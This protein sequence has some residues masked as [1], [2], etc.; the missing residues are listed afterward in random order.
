MKLQ[1]VP[2]SA[3]PGE[4]DV[5]GLPAGFA[6]SV[7]HAGHCWRVTLLSEGRHEDLGEFDTSDEA[8]AALEAIFDEGP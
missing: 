5:A 3:Q 4:F 7:E 8:V 6:A 1:L 2:S